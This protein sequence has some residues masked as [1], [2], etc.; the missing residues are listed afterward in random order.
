[1]QIFRINAKQRLLFNIELLAQMC[2]K[3]KITIDSKKK[4][5]DKGEKD[6]DI[7]IFNKKSMQLHF[8]PNENNNNITKA[9]F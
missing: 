7:I 3:Y 4:N 8:V 6:K 2:K 9:K 1:M 5:S